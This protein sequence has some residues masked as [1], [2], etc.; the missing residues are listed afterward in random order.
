MELGLMEERNR[1]NNGRKK[2]K[3]E[4]NNIMRRCKERK[5]KEWKKR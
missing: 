4:K 1:D 5:N 3:K 2:W